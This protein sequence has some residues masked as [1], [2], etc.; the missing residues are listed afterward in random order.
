LCCR[1]YRRTPISIASA[2]DTDFFSAAQ[3]STPSNSKFLLTLKFC[4]EYKGF[5]IKNLLLNSAQSL[6]ELGDPMNNVDNADAQDKN[7][8]TTPP[9]NPEDLENASA[10][11]DNKKEKKSASDR[12]ASGVAIGKDSI[13]LLRDLALSVLVVLLL[14]F[15]T[16]FN[17]V[18]SSAG[19]EEGSF[20]GFKWKPK[21][22]DSDAA[23]KEAQVLITDLREQN[24]KLSEALGA[25]QSKLSDPALKEQ[26][27]K[28]EKENKQLNIASSK[29]ENTVADTIKSNAPLVEKVQNAMDT[30]TKWGVVFSADG[31]LEDAK[32][33]VNTVAPKLGIPNASIYFRQGFYRSVSVTNSKS[34]AEQILS[35]AKQ[36]RSDAYLVSMSNWCANSNDKNDYRECVSP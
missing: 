36:Q 34:E 14:A 20:V 18:L 35:K 12:V 10:P 11:A 28:L 13:A 9:S 21:L 16:T 2:R 22:L 7:K 1:K 31:N 17:N 5:I 6:C 4:V 19:F 29:V 23:L 30:K 3:I 15:P 26:Y 25:A 32:H 8:G 27:A 24:N 33:E